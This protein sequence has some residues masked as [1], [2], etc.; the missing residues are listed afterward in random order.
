MSLIPELGEVESLDIYADEFIDG[1]NK[2]IPFFIIWIIVCFWANSGI[3]SVL[4]LSVSSSCSHKNG[5]CSTFCF[6]TPMGRTCGCQ[7]NVY[8]QSDQLTCQG[9][10]WKDCCIYTK[11]GFIL[12]LMG[13]CCTFDIWDKFHVTTSIFIFKSKSCFSL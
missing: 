2:K 1:I 10:N 12:Q 11:K 6:P 3:V 8:L 7:N 5:M 4:L 13:K 9:G